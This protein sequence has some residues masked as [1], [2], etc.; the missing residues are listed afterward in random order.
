M[1]LRRKGSGSEVPRAPKAAQRTGAEQSAGAGPVQN[2]QGH[3]GAQE[4]DHQAQEVRPSVPPLNHEAIARLGTGNL[5][6]KLQQHFQEQAEKFRVSQKAFEDEGALRRVFVAID[7]VLYSS[8]V[9]QVQ[10]AEKKALEAIHSFVSNAWQKKLAKGPA[11]PHRLEEEAKE[12]VIR[13]VA[14]WSRR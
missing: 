1:A 14:T 11:T 13:Q 12:R 6:A 2:V 4:Q 7:G 3:R 9:D 8:N 10:A 5:H